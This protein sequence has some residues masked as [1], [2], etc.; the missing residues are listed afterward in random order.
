[1]PKILAK[2]HLQYL[3]MTFTYFYDIDIYL[4]KSFRN[5]DLGLEPFSF[6]ILL[7]RALP[8]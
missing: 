6:R 2:L 1:M 8:P 5:Y 3:R 4:K 7:V